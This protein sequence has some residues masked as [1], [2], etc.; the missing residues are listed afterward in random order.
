MPFVSFAQNFEDLMLYRAL[1]DVQNGFYID[2]G[3]ADP[4]GHSVTRAFYDRG[5]RGINV[6]PNP[7]FHQRLAEA[8]PEDV[9]LK[10]AISNKSGEAPFHFIGG[11]HTGLSSLD[12]RTAECHRSQGLSI[13][14]EI[15]AVST[16]QDVCAKH[17]GDRDIHFL[18]LDVE[19]FELEALQ[20]HDFKR[21][22]PWIIVGEAHDAEKT[23]D[24][25]TKWQALLESEGYRFV[26]QDGLN[27]FFVAEER[28]ALAESFQ[29]P[30][31]C[32]DDWESADVAGYR[33]RAEVAEAKV[34]ELQRALEESRARS[35]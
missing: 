15:T 28:S 24:A 14:T 35:A 34:E 8:R 29:W 17:V 11:E 3:A 25:W 10:L 7:W 2:V 20:G 31:N 22:R 12:A 26:Y 13:R 27:R 33:W 6:E 9:N 23:W 5:W 32:Y 21:W 30:P 19:G 1:K 16:L 18:K 4:V